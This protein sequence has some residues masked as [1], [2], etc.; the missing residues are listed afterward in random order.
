[1]FCLQGIAPYSI[2]KTTLLGL[3]KAMSIAGAAMNIRVNG[4][5][6]GIIQ[7]KFSKAVST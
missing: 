7:T 6:P 1:M 5:A 4:I 2:S 3:V